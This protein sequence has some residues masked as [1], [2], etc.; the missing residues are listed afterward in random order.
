MHV[1]R[2]LLRYSACRGP[3]FV[4]RPVL[5]SLDQVADRLSVEKLITGQTLVHFLCFLF[6]AV[7]VRFLALKLRSKLVHTST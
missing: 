2:A 5:E 7:F 1:K 3:I 4:P 6:L